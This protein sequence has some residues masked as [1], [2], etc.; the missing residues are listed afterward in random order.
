MIEGLPFEV[1]FD[2]EEE[3][4]DGEKEDGAAGA[5]DCI[6]S[7]TSMAGAI[8]RMAEVSVYIVLFGLF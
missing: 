4:E 5:G 3:E 6:P 2:A 7:G 8:Y 1:F